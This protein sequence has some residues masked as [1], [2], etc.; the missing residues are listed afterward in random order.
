MSRIEVQQLLLKCRQQP[1]RLVSRLGAAGERFL[2]WTTFYILGMGVATAYVEFFFRVVLKY[3]KETY[4]LTG[5]IY[6]VL[7]LR[8][9]T[10]KILH[11]LKL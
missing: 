2:K 3:R 6:G 5:V 7:I 8:W 4:L 11:W 10:N 1:P 9:V